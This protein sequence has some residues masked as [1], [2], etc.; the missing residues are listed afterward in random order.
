[1]SQPSPDARAVVRALDA[2]TTQV[3][4]LA[5][6]RQ[7]DFVLSTDATDDAP[8]TTADDGP[9]CVCGDPIVLSGDPARWI[10][11]AHPG[12]LPLTDHQIRPA[13]TGCSH[14]GPHPDFTCA[15]VNQS[16]PYWNVRWEQEQQAPAT[17]DDARTARRRSI[18]VLLN[19]LNNGLTLTTDEAQLLTR[20]VATEITDANEGRRRAE[21]AEDLLRV[22]HETSNRSEA[23]RSEEERLRLAL[24]A[25]RDRWKER[26]EQARHERDVIAVD[27]ETAN[28]LRAEVQRER[29][30]QAAV[31]A[32]VL[33]HFTEHGHPGAPCVRTPWIR[34]DT[35]DRWRSVVWHDVERPWWQQV[36]EAQAELE[37]AQAAIE[38]VRAALKV[39]SST[40]LPRSEAH[41][42]LADVRAALDGT[43]QPTTGCVPGPYDDCPN[44][45][46]DETEQPTMEP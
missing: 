42:V 37:Q 26:A 43:E 4:R 46:H 20:H 6:S 34:T 5:D 38:R 31:L 25:E 33:R 9:H 15:E 17:D 11:A 18:R 3:R 16:R 10:H 14:R 41:Q 29:D 22:A 19:R 7:S 35:V 30:Q 27:L 8:T 32:E 13:L 44:C 28:R 12:L 36:D 1:V 45:P 40:A 24:A 21:Q 23:A 2:L 39:W